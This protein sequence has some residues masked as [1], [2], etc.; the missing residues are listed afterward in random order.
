MAEAKVFTQMHGNA[1]SQPLGLAKR[2]YGGR[3]VNRPYKKWLRWGKGGEA[4]GRPAPLRES[5]LRR[6]IR[7]STL[8]VPMGLP[9]TVVGGDLPNSRLCLEYG[10]ESPVGG[11]G[12]C[13]S[14]HANAWERRFTAVGVGKKGSRRSI[15]ESTLQVGLPLTVVGG[16][17]PNSRLC[18]GGVKSEESHAKMQREIFE[19]RGLLFGTFFTMMNIRDFW[20]LRLS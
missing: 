1:V 5:G 12:G 10:Q 18:R 4:T 17:L 8:Q 20:E 16:D 11:D 19:K 15:R 14:F 2:G 7:E 9:L 13:E 3:F 6:S